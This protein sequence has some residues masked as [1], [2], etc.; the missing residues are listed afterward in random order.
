MLSLE[1]VIYREI[2]GKEITALEAYQNIFQ[3]GTGLTQ[4][5]ADD[6]NRVGNPIAYFRNQNEETGHFRIMFSEQFEDILAE[7]QNADFAILNGLSYFGRKN[8]QQYADKMFSM[9]FDLDGQTPQTLRNFFSGCVGGWYPMPNYVALSG[10][11]VH[12]YYIFEEPVKLYPNLKM[13]LKELKYQLAKKMWNRNTSTEE[14]V[15]QQG[16]NQGFRVLGGKTKIDGVK[17]RVFQIRENKY[18]LHELCSY[19]PEEFRVDEKKLYKESKLTLEEAKVKYPAWYEKVVVNKDN[20]RTYWDIAGKVNGKNPY[21]LYDWWLKRVRMEASYGHRYYC[22]L[23][24]AVYGVKCGKPFEDVQADALALLPFFNFLKPDEPFTED[25]VL[26]ALECYD[27]KYC[28]FPIR[29][30]ETLASI[31]IQRNKRNGRTLE[32]HT[33][34]MRTIKSFKVK[35]GEC[36]NG[37]GRKSA[38]PVVDAWR[39]AHPDGTVRECVEAT[40]LSAPTVYKHWTKR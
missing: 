19:V 14:K 20:S 33:E 35:M 38:K 6:N 31:P 3:L 25:D 1:E 21:A 13:Q 7:L 40:G 18:P 27:L 9:I 30:I 15:Q 36:V 39:A 29:S 22:C 32:Q 4:Y 5:N 26:A 17:V 37:G 23:S 16:I 8:V 34:Y 11:G 12:L 28:T 10:H 24:M 2:N